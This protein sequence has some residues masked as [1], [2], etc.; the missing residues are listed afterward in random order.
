MTNNEARRK[1]PLRNQEIRAAIDGAGLRYWWV[2]EELGVA[3]G[4]LS[5]RL[6]R[7]LPPEEKLDILAAVKRLAERLG[8]P[9]SPAPRRE[10]ILETRAT[11]PGGGW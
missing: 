4:T 7:E 5:N 11:V 3:S 1:R 2:A 6:R 8:A 10:V 9:P